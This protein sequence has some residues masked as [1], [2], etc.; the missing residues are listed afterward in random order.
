MVTSHIELHWFYR[1]SKPKMEHIRV[2]SSMWRATCSFLK[3]ESIVTDYVRAS[4]EDIDLLTYEG[5]GECRRVQY[6]NIRGHKGSNITVAFWQTA[7]FPFHTDS[8]S[9]NCNYTTTGGVSN[10]DNFG[11]Y[12]RY[13][14]NFRCTEA[15]NATT[16]Y[17]LG[18]KVKHK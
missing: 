12:F 5:D 11:N 3:Y 9:K 8:T 1:L 14:E 2:N 13:N 7:G 17:W 18:V 6:I 16:Q 15:E 4:L 10:E